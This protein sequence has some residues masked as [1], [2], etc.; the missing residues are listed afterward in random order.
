[1]IRIASEPAR[2][3]IGRAD[4]GECRGVYHTPISSYESNPS[5]LHRLSEALKCGRSELRHLVE[6]QHSVVCERHLTGAWRT[7]S[8]DQTGDR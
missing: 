1:M 8:P 2:A 4:Q 7:S 6:E 5:I 3:R